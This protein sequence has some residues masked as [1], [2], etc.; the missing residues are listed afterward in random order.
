MFEGKSRAALRTFL[1][2]AFTDTLTFDETW[3]LLPY[4]NLFNARNYTTAA[5]NH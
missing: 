1:V 2:G 3:S 5:T 4:S